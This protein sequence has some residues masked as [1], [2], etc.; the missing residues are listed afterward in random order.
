VR[1]VTCILAVSVVFAPRASLAQKLPG[2]GGVELRLGIADPANADQGYTYAL[3]FD[4]GYL[5]TPSLRSYIGLEG[6]K[7]D[8]AVKVAGADVGGSIKGTGLE[9]GVRYDLLP[10]GRFSPYGVAGLNFSNVSANGVS[11]P[12]T[13]DLLDGFRVAVA[14]GAGL[15][16]RLGTQ[17]TWSVVGDLRY[18][19]G[20]NVG[21]T[22]VTAGLRW[23]PHGRSMYTP[24]PKG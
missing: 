21:R 8:V 19:T 16:W 2:F 23:S 5:G 1:A 3:E 17:H 22:V 10:E 9:T 20:T 4:P 14:F 15:A 11:E 13:E 6:F 18:V 24:E 12:S 7:S